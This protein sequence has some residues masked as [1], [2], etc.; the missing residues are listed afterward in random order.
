MAVTVNVNGLTL[1]HKGSD[2]VSTATIP[3]VCKTP[4]P[5]GPVPIPYPNVAKSSDLAKGTTTVS[6]DGG[7]MCASGLL[8]IVI[9]DDLL[10]VLCNVFCETLEAGEEFKKDPAN[11]GKKFN[12]SSHAKKLSESEK[13]AGHFAKYGMKSE[14]KLLVRVGENTMQGLKRVGDATKRKL[15]TAEEAV[16]RLRSHAHAKVAKMVGRKVAGKAAKSLVAK[17]IPVVNVISLAV[18]V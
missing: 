9:G 3:D 18:D 10:N 8:Q 13:Y 15:Y 2:G 6:A 1:C 12:Y 16:K 5:G 14:A 4:A 7:N 17:F 11:A